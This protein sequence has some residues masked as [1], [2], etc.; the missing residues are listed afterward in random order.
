MAVHSDIGIYPLFLAYLFGKPEQVKAVA[1]LGPTLVDHSCSM[2]LLYQNDLVAHLFSS[3]VA[4]TD[5]VA[6]ICSFRRENRI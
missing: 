2:S 4:Q 6:E 5:V 1:G 3:V